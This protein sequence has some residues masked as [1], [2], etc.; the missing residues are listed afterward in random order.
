M[1]K[2]LSMLATV[3]I[4]ILALLIPYTCA[5]AQ[6]P[7]WVVY[8]TSNSGL[9]SN[10]VWS[11]AIEGN[12]TKWMANGG[13]W[14]ET[15]YAGGCGITSFD[16][17]TWTVYDTSNSGLPSNEVFAIAID[18]N[19]TKWVG[20]D[21]GL[22]SFDGTIWTVFDTTNSAL[23][24]SIIDLI[25]IDD[26]GTKWMEG[27]INYYD[28]DGVGLISF[29][30]TSWVVYDSSNSGLPNNYITSIG[31]DN[32]G[33]KWIG[34]YGGG[35]ASFDGIDWVVYNRANSVLSDDRIASI[36][37]EGDGTLWVGDRCGLSSFDGTD[38]SSYYLPHVGWGATSIASLAIDDSGTKWIGI[39]FRDSNLGL[40]HG[41]GLCRYDNENWVFYDTSN[42]GLPDDYV[43]S[44]VIDADGNKWLSTTYAQFFTVGSGLVVYNESGVVGINT[45][46]PSFR[47]VDFMLLQNYPNPFNPTTTISYALPEQSKVNLTVFDILGQELITLQEDVQAAGNYKLQWSGKDQLGNP[48]S[49]G[50]YFARL[51]VVDSATDG[52]GAFSK[53]IKMLYLK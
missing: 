33:A 47:P 38:W 39:G 49:T 31:I 3:T 19:G 34:T 10:N 36:A 50:V 27:L 48:V 44:I 20:T 24:A 41:V 7:E 12:G 22:A 9:P 29:D 45:E 42:S 21:Q 16:G 43:S 37:I 14:S 13:G 51:Q 28:E 40:F 18:G 52:A 26:G 6:N 30:G 35:L 2:I 53:T 25:V 17:T 8:D 15:G 11:I 46:E 1:N 4:G 32:N 5:L 23:N